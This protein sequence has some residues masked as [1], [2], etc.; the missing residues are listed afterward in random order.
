V[1]RGAYWTLN[2]LYSDVALQQFNNYTIWEVENILSNA[3]LYFGD[4]GLVSI[5][6]ILISA[7]KCSICLAILVI[8]IGSIQRET[9]PDSVEASF[10]NKQDSMLL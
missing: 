10:C 5:V 2:W 3:F 9:Y 4:D 1:E 6:D 7:Q 8:D